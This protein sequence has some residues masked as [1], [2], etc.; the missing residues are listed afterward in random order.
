MKASERCFRS[1][2]ADILFGYAQEAQAYRQD[3]AELLLDLAIKCDLGE[4]L[5]CTSDIRSAFPRALQ[6]AF[7]A[8]H[9]MQ[10]E[11]ETLIYEEE[12]S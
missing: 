5:R 12:E 1:C 4:R 8:R 10:E 7:G 9:G 2:L 11:M 6:D 3:R